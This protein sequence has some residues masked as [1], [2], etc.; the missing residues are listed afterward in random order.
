[1]NSEQSGDMFS[2]N[3][4]AVID[5]PKAWAINK[6]LAQKLALIGNFSVGEFFQGLTDEDS[7]FLSVAVSTTNM[8]DDIAS[9]LFLMMT[10][11]SMAEGLPLDEGDM[12]LVR[13]FE[14]L[15]ILITCDA[16]AR[17]GLAELHYD[18]MSM[19]YD[20]RM[21]DLVKAT[22]EGIALIAHMLGGGDAV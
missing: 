20:M 12:D 5:S 10:L 11:L 18:K 6:A 14:S 9:E 4:K 7:S 17:K 1:M 21:V 8:E 19:G 15:I 13:R 16:L 22:P 2:I 3:L